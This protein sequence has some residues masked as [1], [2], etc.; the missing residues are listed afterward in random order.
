MTIVTSA[1]KYSALIYTIIPLAW[2][3]RYEFLS[4]S[5]THIRCY[6][7]LCVFPIFQ[8]EEH[9]QNQS[10]FDSQ[11]LPS[12]LP[13]DEQDKSSTSCHYFTISLDSFSLNSKFE[14]IHDSCALF[15]SSVQCHLRLHR[16][17]IGHRDRI[18]RTTG[19]GFQSNQVIITKMQGRCC[20]QPYVLK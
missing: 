14:G 15:R 7:H 11:L 18:S 17:R 12:Q 10:A 6:G 20:I 3:L 5:L 16:R 1:R 9:W 8:I 19:A 13:Q 2:Y 4:H